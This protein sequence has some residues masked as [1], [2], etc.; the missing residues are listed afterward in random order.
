MARKSHHMP[1]SGSDRKALT[2]ELG[3]TH[4]IGAKFPTYLLTTRNSA[5]MPAG[6]RIIYS[7]PRG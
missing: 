3:K 4:G 5:M 2:K 6:H 1:L 7:S